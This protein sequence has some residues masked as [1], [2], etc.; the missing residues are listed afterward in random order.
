MNLAATRIFSFVSPMFS[1]KS[2]SG[3]TRKMYFSIST[4]LIRVPMWRP[5]AKSSSSERR[6]FS[7]RGIASLSS[8]SWLSMRPR[9]YA[10]SARLFA[11]TCGYFRNSSI[12]STCVMS[13][14]LQQYRRIPSSSR[15]F[16][17]LSPALTRWLKVSHLSAICFP[18][19]KHLT[20][21]IIG[22]SLPVRFLF[23]SS[24]AWSTELFGFCDSLVSSYHDSIVG[25]EGLSQLTSLRP[26]CQRSGYCYAGSF[27]L[28]HHSATLDADSDIHAFRP[29]P[30]YQQRLLDLHSCDFWVHVIE[31][32]II[33]VNASL[34]RPHYCSRDCGFSLACF[35]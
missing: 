9:P 19:V 6:R 12:N 8:N 21:I 22:Q 27:C 16:W 2:P 34:P 4:V 33:D 5:A 18:H 28:G 1:M 17:G 15:T 25:E 11:V 29:F 26:A 7:A 13:I 30:S 23:S 10:S 31:R 3:L 35:K 24:C 20:G 32:L 14:R